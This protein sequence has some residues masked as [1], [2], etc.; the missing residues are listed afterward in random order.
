MSQ[1]TYEITKLAEVTTPQF[2]AELAEYNLNW[3]DGRPYNYEGDNYRHGLGKFWVL[4][5]WDDM[6]EDYI[7]A[8][9]SKWEA[10]NDVAKLIVAVE[11]EV[12]MDEIMIR[13]A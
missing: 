1:R 12:H 9:T 2:R 4:Q 10:I 5:W 8:Y 6:G 11:R 7:R 13:K 3:I